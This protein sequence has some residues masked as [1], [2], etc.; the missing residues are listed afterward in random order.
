MIA[1]PALALMTWAKIGATALV[2]VVLVSS[3]VLRDKR[4]ATKA[5]QEDRA[6]TEQAN[7]KVVK[8]ATRAAERSLDPSVRGVVDP[9]TR[10]D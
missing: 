1:L 3:C 10:R 2:V 6:A 9:S 7:V 5:V 8:K 4:I